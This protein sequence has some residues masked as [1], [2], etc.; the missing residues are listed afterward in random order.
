MLALRDQ[1]LDPAALTAFAA[2]LGELEV[3]R[4]AQALPGHPYV[5][6]VI[7]EPEDKSKLRRHLAHRF[8]LPAAAAEPEDAP[9]TRCSVP[10]TRRRHAVRHAPGPIRRCRR[11]LRTQ[12]DPM[13]C[14][15]TPRRSYMM[16]AGAFAGRGRRRSQIDAARGR[17]LPT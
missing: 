8:E 16:T 13:S 7:K 14:A 9:G 1:Q 17:L 15:V 5:V 4:F 12:N 10:K 3:Y 6:P 11:E 2:K